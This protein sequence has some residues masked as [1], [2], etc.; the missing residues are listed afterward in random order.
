[1]PGPE[2]FAQHEAT[3]IKNGLQSGDEHVADQVYRDL[4]QQYKNGSKDQLNAE[5]NGKG[6]INAELH[7]LG[8][9]AIRLQTDERGQPL[10]IVFDAQDHDAKPRQSIDAQNQPCP[11][12]LTAAKP[13][14]QIGHTQI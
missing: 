8:L 4:M 12:P 10:S 6:G 1:M 5:V 11:P 13:D 14:T 7:K 2:N 3:K 9:P